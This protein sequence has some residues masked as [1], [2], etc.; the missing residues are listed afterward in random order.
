LR[1]SSVYISAAAACVGSG[2]PA[3]PRLVNNLHP[4]KLHGPHFQIITLPLCASIKDRVIIENI[5]N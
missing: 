1:G 5:D 4:R 2:R 3:I